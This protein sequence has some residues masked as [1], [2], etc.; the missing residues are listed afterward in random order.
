MTRIAANRALIGLS[1][2]LAPYW[3]LILSGVAWG[4]WGGGDPITIGQ[5]IVM[6]A[7]QNAVTLPLDTSA[8]APVVL[9]LWI[10]AIVALRR[11]EP[12]ARD[13]VLTDKLTL[14]VALPY[15]AVGLY[16]FVAFAVFWIACSLKPC[17][18]LW[19]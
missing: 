6:V 19:L 11:G 7:Q 17:S 12:R 10:A 15:L 16:F 9:A 1:V 13:L 8:L 4:I 18:F 2:A 5:S 3:F 14:V